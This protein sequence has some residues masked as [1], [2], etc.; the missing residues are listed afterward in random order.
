MVKVMIK[1]EVFSYLRPTTL[2]LDYS[3]PPETIMILPEPAQSKLLTI[4]AKN[5]RTLE[6]WNAEQA[7]QVPYRRNFPFATIFFD[8]DYP[9]GGYVTS[10][11]WDKFD[12]PYRAYKYP[13]EENY[14]KCGSW[15]FRNKD[16]LRFSA[17]R[18]PIA[19]RAWELLKDNDPNTPWAVFMDTLETE[20]VSSA[21]EMN[22]QLLDLRKTDMDLEN[23]F[24]FNPEEMTPQMEVEVSP[25][26]K[27][28]LIWFTN[29]YVGDRLEK[30]IEQ[31]QK[32]LVDLVMMISAIYNMKHIRP[33]MTVFLEREHDLT[34]HFF[35]D[36]GFQAGELNFL[37][38][39]DDFFLTPEEFDHH[40]PFGILFFV[41]KNEMQHRASKS[42]LINSWW[43]RVKDLRSDRGFMIVPA[44][45]LT[46]YEELD[47]FACTGNA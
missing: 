41:T 36:C 24:P 43:E 29:P 23:T 46:S 7:C 9:L 10:R 22:K 11:R 26:I 42:S 34:S 40:F 47:I 35:F 17:Q 13:P 1:A 21:S 45:D 3:L 6:H 8:Q 20:F 33:W 27:G 25:V 38:Y 18:C 30:I 39:T 37:S 16:K 2:E 44:E 5:D 15:W 12:S 31:Y 19:A 28:T 4:L 32:N 14:S